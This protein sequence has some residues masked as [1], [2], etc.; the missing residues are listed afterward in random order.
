M[1]SDGQPGSIVINYDMQ[2]VWLQVDV[3]I[4]VS[5]RAAVIAVLGLQCQGVYK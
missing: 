4:A 5:V 3:R 1:G 2:V